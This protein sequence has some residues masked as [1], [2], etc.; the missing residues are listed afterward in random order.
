MDADTL[1]SRKLA[2]RIVKLLESEMPTPANLGRAFALAL[3]VHGDD[4]SWRCDELNGQAM[5]R[6]SQAFAHTMRPTYTEPA[7][8]EDKP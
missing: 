8:R 4:N 1:A 5:Y 6:F 7:T 2:A 3:R